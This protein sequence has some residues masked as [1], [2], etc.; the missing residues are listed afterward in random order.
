M[1]VAEL[2]D[3]GVGIDTPP[4]ERERI[5]EAFFT[6]KAKGTGLGL[7]TVQQIVVDHGGRVSLVRT[8][9]TGTVFEVQLPACAPA[10]ASVSSNIPDDLA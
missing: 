5:F 9:P 4:E 1:E 10:G 6:S 7:S 3:T 8:G 2:F